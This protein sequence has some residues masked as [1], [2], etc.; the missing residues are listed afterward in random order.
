MASIRKRGESYQIIVSKGYKADGTKITESTTYTP[1]PGA[2]KRFIELDLKAFAAEF[3]RSVKAGK[4]VR[5]GRMRLE[6]LARQYLAD[7]QPP[8]L[9]RTTYRDYTDR[10][11]NRIL[12]AMGHMQIANIRQKDINDYCK[13]LHETYR[14]PQTGKKL[15]E[16]TI[17]KDCAVISTLMSYAVAE[18]YLEM[19]YLIYAGKM[20]N[21]RSGAK[22]ATEVKYFTI[23]QLIRFIDALEHEESKWKLYFYIALFAG[24]RRGENIALTW[25]DLNMDTGRLNI[26]KA[27]DY[28]SGSGMGIKDTKTHN[29]RTNTL[30]QYVIE[31]AKSWKREQ[32]ARCLKIG[33]RWVGFRGK[34]YDQNFIFTQQNGSQMH[35]CSPYTKYK[36]LIRAY[37]D[38]IENNQDKIPESV[39]P[40]GLRH[41]A[42]AIMIAG[43]MDAR[44][45]A[46]V[47]GH[48]NPTTTLNIYSYFFADKGSEAAG[49]MEQMLLGKEEESKTVVK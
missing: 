24:D 28:V 18:G 43:N 45:V 2:T 27:T 15:S 30:P 47:L 46:G 10:L 40:H 1:E 44:T 5:G 39:P 9:A 17:R 21:R 13:M 26:D 4:N 7:M 20:H 6:N 25:A 36:R 35:I 49:I 16:A 38:G 34:D 23:E 22:K 8:A 12:P 29:S 42:A 41:S 11:E 32:M 48:K 14:N 31:I 37:N 19:N 33:D 3:E